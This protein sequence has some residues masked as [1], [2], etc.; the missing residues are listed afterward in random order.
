MSTACKW[1][2]SSDAARSTSPSPTSP[3]RPRV[4]ALAGRR[5]DG[6]ADP[7]DQHASAD[8]AGISYRVG[9]P[10]CIRLADGRPDRVQRD[11]AGRPAGVPAER[12]RRIVVHHARARSRVTWWDPSG[13]SRLMDQGD[14]GGYGQFGS[15]GTAAWKSLEAPPSAGPDRT[16][17]R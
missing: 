15:S 14:A 8:G 5:G 1:V 16:A 7:V 6:V 3:A 12:G 9:E 17:A 11:L 4:V 10:V 2:P 13:S